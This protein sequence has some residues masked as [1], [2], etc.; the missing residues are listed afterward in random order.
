MRDIKEDPYQWKDRLTLWVGKL[1]IQTSILPNLRL[2][3]NIFPVMILPGWLILFL[4]LVT[5][6]LILKC[7]KRVTRSKTQTFW[8][9]EQKLIPPD[10]KTNSKSIAVSTKYAMD[11]MSVLLK[12]RYLNI[13]LRIDEPVW[14]GFRGMSLLEEICPWK[15]ALRL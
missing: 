8:K 10:P 2:N 6:F 3:I 9:Q 13:L 15:R 4:S 7:I 1:N 5:S 11:W 14:R 12:L